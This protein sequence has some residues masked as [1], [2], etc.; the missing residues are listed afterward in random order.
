[1]CTDNAG[2]D[3]PVSPSANEH[4]KSNIQARGLVRSDR[5]TIIYEVT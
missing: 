3:H 4:Y 2:Y 1:M 5:S